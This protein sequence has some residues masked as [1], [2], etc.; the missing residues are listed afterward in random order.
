VISITKRM[1]SVCAATLL[2]LC[3]TFDFGNPRVVIAGSSND[4]QSFTSSVPM[5]PIHG[6]PADAPGRYIPDPH[7]LPNGYTPAELKNLQSSGRIKIQPDGRIEYLR[8][9]ERDIATRVHNQREQA[10]TGVSAAPPAGWHSSDS[11]VANPMAQA[12]PDVSNGASPEPHPIK[13]NSN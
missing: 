8:P 6:I 12:T 2:F 7:R 10:L 1:S 13:P 4:E 3:A 11:V 9:S 5:Q